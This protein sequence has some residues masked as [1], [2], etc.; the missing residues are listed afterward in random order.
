MKKYLVLILT[1][2]FS[3]MLVYADG[4]CYYKITV[5]GECECN[6]PIVDGCPE[7]VTGTG[8]YKKYTSSEVLYPIVSDLEE[9]WVFLQVGTMFSINTCEELIFCE[10]IIQNQGSYA[11]PN[12]LDCESGAG[13]FVFDVFGYDADL[14]QNIPKFTVS[15][16]RL[17]SCEEYINALP[18]MGASPE[19]PDLPCNCDCD[20]DPA[21]GTEDE[22]YD[23]QGELKPDQ[24][25]PGKPLPPINDPVMPNSGALVAPVTD[26]VVPGRMMDI[27]FTRT[28][29]GDMDD[30]G[31]KHTF[32]SPGK[33]QK[34]LLSSNQGLIDRPEEFDFPVTVSSFASSDSGRIEQSPLEFYSYIFME[35]RESEWDLEYD[36]FNVDLGDPNDPNNVGVI[37]FEDYNGGSATVTTH[38][39]V[40]GTNDPN[41]GDPLIYF[42]QHPEGS[43]T[44]ISTRTFDYEFSRYAGRLGRKWDHS[45]NISLESIFDPNDQAPEKYVLLAGNAKRLLF[46]QEPDTEFGESSVYRCPSNTDELLYKTEAGFQLHKKGGTIWKFNTDLRITAI[47]DLNGNQTTFQYSNGNL[48]RV[49]NDAGNYITFYYDSLNMIDYIVDSFGRTFDYNRDVYF[50]LAEVLKPVNK[51]KRSAYTYAADNL[52]LTAIDGDN[53]VWQ[54]NIYDSEGRIVAQRYGDGYFNNIYHLN[55]DGQV[56]YVEINDRNGNQQQVH[57]T[58]TGLIRKEL[59]MVDSQW[60]ETLYYYDFDVNGTD[61]AE[62][63]CLIQKIIRPEGDIYEYEYDQWG[64]TTAIIH[65][66]DEAD[67]GL[68]TEY[69]YSNSIWGYP[70]SVTDPAGYT[71]DY[72]YDYMEPEN[73]VDPSGRLVGVRLPESYVSD[74][75]D[76]DQ[77]ELLS[78]E[79]RFAYNEYGQVTRLTLPTGVCVDFEYYDGSGKYWLKKII[80]DHGNS[81][82]N[83]NITQ[84]YDYDTFGNTTMFTDADGYTTSYTYDIMSRLTEIIDAVNYKTVLTYNRAGMVE[85]AGSQLGSFYN[86]NTALASEF[87]YNTVDKLT[88]ITD[89]LGRVTALG[90]DGNDNL[91]TLTDPQGYV[92]GYSVN[93]GYNSLDLLEEITKPEDYNTAEG[94]D[95]VTTF[96]YYKDGLLKSAI[97]A[98]GNVTYYEYDGYRRLSEISYPDGSFVDYVYDKC[99][100]VVRETKRDG[101]V[102][103]YGYNALGNLIGKGLQSEGSVLTMNSVLTDFLCTGEWIPQED[104][105]CSSLR[106]TYSVND[107]NATYSMYGFGLNEGRIGVELRWISFGTASSSQVE[108]EIYDEI[109]GLV[110]TVFVDQQFNGD[111]WVYLGMYDF[112]DQPKIKIKTNGDPRIVTIDAVRFVPAKVFEYDAMGRVTKAHGCKFEYDHVG[113][114]LKSTDGFGREV[115]YEYTP[116]GRRSKLIWPDGYYVTYGY[117]AAGRPSSIVD[118]DGRTLWT[119]LYDATGRREQTTGLYGL[120]SV[121]DYED[122]GNGDDDRG[123]YLK[124]L[125]NILPDGTSLKFDYTYDFAG[126]KLTESVNSSNVASY[127]YDKNYALTQV[128]YNGGFDL[129][130]DYDNLFNRILM[131]EDDSVNSYTTNYTVNVEGTNGYQTIGSDNVTYDSNGNFAS[132]GTAN[133]IY[134]S[135]NNLVAYYQMD[136]DPNLTAVSLY[137]YDVF[138][139]RTNRAVSQG[140]GSISGS[141]DESYLYDGEQAIGEYT[142]DGEH[143]K[144]RFVYGPGIDEPIC[145]V[146]EPDHK[147]YYGFKEFSDINECWNTQTGDSGYNPAYDYS[148]DGSIDFADVVS[149]IGDYYLT[150]RPLEEVTKRYGYVYDGSGN[151]KALTFRNDPNQTGNP[152]EETF[153]YETYNY[154]VFGTPYIYDANGISCSD[155]LVKNPYMFT[156]RRYDTESGLYYYRMRMYNPEIGRFMQNDPI[157]YYDGMNL[158]QYCGN[159]PVNFT[160]PWGLSKIGDAA[161]GWARGQEGNSKYGRQAPEYMYSQF[162]RDAYMNAGAPFPKRWWNRNGSRFW[163]LYPSMSPPTP[164]EMADPDYRMPNYPPVNGN[165][166]KITRDDL[167]PGDIIS[168]PGECK[169]Y[170]GIYLGNGQMIKA[171][172]LAP[173]ANLTTIHPREWNQ[174]LSGKARVRRYSPTP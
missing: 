167:Q 45:Y 66:M 170:G 77:L 57:L 160:D 117:D 169:G 80:Y 68:R 81:S 36:C 108:V 29:R 18:G 13:S 34:I 149:F 172:I 166:K 115:G 75:N 168:F 96:T 110:D 43:L 153:F 73:Y 113:R 4:P 30:P 76:I 143:I 8:I 151:V 91:A 103:C 53:K 104:P 48:E 98:D 22:I 7:G 3:S 102:A 135:Q 154:D 119:C 26:F 162:I 74:V 124:T 56:S 95:N 2:F 71:I 21:C 128:D 52:L 17:C 158:Y 20:T 12:F 33:G 51:D 150:D 100:R 144:R 40:Y 148:Q 88:K 58:S 1:L 147:G 11:D 139:R 97:D 132:C 42:N 163:P 133:Y 25:D 141:V 54:E 67:P 142:S 9:S 72:I 112:L 156:G 165:G 46:I 155:S 109:G 19:D 94:N 131:T 125:W 49:T 86:Q 105:N 38:Y 15:I 126:N 152:L 84:L 28:Y 47:E 59:K 50:N 138:G 121:Y 39:C 146:V 6:S 23:N 140:I 90:Y 41:G 64:N 93:Y 111:Q 161:A 173:G 171:S 85:T 83:L 62:S 70:E 159:N 114:L 79:Y 123:L 55:E 16:S 157:G 129:I 5:D 127:L 122:E 137:G 174:I 99:G 106:Y 32:Y 134:D 92:D 27:V 118:S 69:T 37:S 65:K 107:P 82:G 89:C 24:N 145:L 14:D 10:G 116:A 136:G 101:S 164:N 87:T 31:F 61:E 60:A 130:F 120:T 44:S 63:D 78:A 35:I